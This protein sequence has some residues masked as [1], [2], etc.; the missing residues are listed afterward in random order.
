ML[1]ERAQGTCPAAAPHLLLR[2]QRVHLALGL[3]GL[4][5]CLGLEALVLGLVSS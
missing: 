2:L 4:H 1:P 3:A 5:P